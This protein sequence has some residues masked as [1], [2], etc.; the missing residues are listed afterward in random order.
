MNLRIICLLLFSL[1]FAVT[2]G[3][4]ADSCPDFT[5][6][7]VVV[8]E[9]NISSVRLINDREQT[10]FK[11]DMGLRDDEI[12]HVFE[13]AIKFYNETYG[14]DFS[15]AKPNEQMEYFFENAKMT[16]FR[17]SENVHYKLVLNNWIQTGRTRTT[18][19]DVQIGGYLVTFTGDQLLRGSY[20]GVNGIPAGVGDFLEYGYNIID[21]CDQSPVIMEIQNA[22]PFRREP[23]DGAVFLDFDIYDNVL[24]YGKALGFIST[25]PLQHNPTVYRLVAR[26]VFT[27]PAF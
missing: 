4:Y 15:D 16:L 5:A 25:K 23:V 27:F 20:G 11:Y 2:L 22:S 18:C 13:D 1:G 12:E 24:G 8:M 14:L 9:Q 21:V 6:T 10:F 26:V 7:F 19:R 17:F 3:D